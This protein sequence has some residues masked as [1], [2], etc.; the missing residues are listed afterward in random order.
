MVQGRNTRNPLYL[1]LGNAKPLE[2]FVFSC[3]LTKI[4]LNFMLDNKSLNAE[5]CCGMP[6]G[7]AGTVGDKVI[8]G[9]R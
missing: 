1:S 2:D 7:F 9:A 6:G 4:V 3:L 5:N 8:T